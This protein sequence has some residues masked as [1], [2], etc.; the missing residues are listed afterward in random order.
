MTQ[1]QLNNNKASEES[2][3]QK[4]QGSV[5]APSISM[6]KGGGAIRGIGEKFAANP[7]TGTGSMSVPIA[8]SPGRAG[9]G[10]QL[11]LSYDSGAGNGPFG[12][13]W[14]MSLPS[15]TRKT[16][17]GLPRYFNAEDSDEFILSGA[18]DLV[19]VLFQNEVGQ[20]IEDLPTRKINNQRYTIRGYRPRIEGLFARIER[21]TNQTDPTDVFWRSISKDNITTW[22]GK[23]EESRIADPEDPRRIFSWLICESHDD[24]GNV[25][26]YRYKAED[27]VK[28][29]LT[30]AHESNRSDNSRTANRYLKRI[31]YGHFEP[32]YPVLSE[33]DPW[34][35]P[36]GGSPTKIESEDP[37]WHF[38]AVFDYG[39]HSSSDSLTPNEDQN[40]QPRA[41]PFSSFR[42]GFEIR[43]YRLCQR[44]L[45]F[46]HF[47]DEPDVGENCLVRS[48][49]FN[50]AYEEIDAKPNPIHTVLNSVTQSG[51]KKTAGNGYQKKSLPPLEFEYSQPTIS[52]KIIEVDAE[53]LEN[54]PYGLDGSVYQWVDLDGE[55]LSGILTE[56]AT[57]WF[58]KANLSP[59]PQT[60]DNG[61]PQAISAK[62]APVRQVAEKPSLAA[63]NSGRQQFLDLAG[64][65]QLDLVELEGSTPGFY[66]RTHQE[67]WESHRTFESLPNLEWADPNLKFIDLTGDGHADIMITED[68][69]F[70]WFPSLAEAG[71]GPPAYISKAL[72]EDQ[73]PRLVFADSTQSIYLSDMSG[74]GLTDMVRLRNGEVCYWPNLGYG[75]FGA[76]ITMDNAPWYDYPDLFDQKR[77][78]LADIDGSGIADILYLSPEG[79]KIYYNQSGNGWSE[80]NILAGFPPIDN[81]STVQAMDLLGNG[82][83][84][85]VWSSPLSANAAQPMRYIDLMGGQ[86]PHLLIKSTNNLG[87][88]THVYYAPSTKFYLQDRYNSKPWVTKI[89]FPVHVV[90]RVE[91]ID[92]ISKSRFSSHY[93]YHHG[94]FDGVEREFRGFGMVEQWDTEEYTAIEGN[95][96]FLQ[97]TNIDK[98]SHMPPM[99]TKTWFHTGAYLGGAEI[100]LLFAKDYYG[101]PA[102]DD[103]EYDQKFTAFVNEQLLPDTILEPGL[104]VEEARGACRSLKGAMLRQE[105]Y[106]DDGTD[107]AQH[108]YTVT[109]QNFTIRYLQPR[110]DSPHAVFF[111]HAREALS[112]H[113]ERN[114]VDPRIQH[115]L[116]LEVDE[117]GN[118]LKSVAIGYGRQ[119]GNSPIHGVD[120]EKQE[121]LLITYTEND[122]TRNDGNYSLTDP[123]KS[124]DVYRIPLPCETRTYE[125]TGLQPEQNQLRFNIDYFT[126]NNFEN[127]QT[128]VSIEYEK[129]PDTNA[130]Q[131]RLIEHVR[132]LYKANQL[133]GPLALGELQSLALPYE[134]YKLAFTPGFL[135]TVFKRNEQPL[136][137]NIAEVLEKKAGDGGGYV[138]LD[139]DG[140]WWI[141]SGRIFFS[142]NETD[143]PQA[144]LALARRSFFT[145]RRYCDPFGHSATVDFDYCLLIKETRDALGNTA[146]AV[147]DFR[148]LQPRQMTDPNGNRTAADF[149]A[150]GLVVATALMGKENET[151]P[152]NIGDTLADPTTRL[153]YELF[154]WK[155]HGQ[156]NF[157]HTSARERHG[158]ANPRWQESY[159]YSDG[160]GR[161]LQTKIQAE[162]GNAPLREESDNPYK[163][164]ALTK[165]AEGQLIWTHTNPRWVGT[166]RTVYN[167]K[168]KPVKQYEPFFSSTPL[169]EE[170]REVTDTGVSPVLFYDPV[171][172]VI[173]TLHPNHTYDKVMFDPWRQ[174]TYD[175]N[176]T[177]AVSGDETGDPRTDPDIAGYV[178][179]YFEEQ[180]ANWQ[181]WYEQRIDGA[182]GDP[183]RAAAEKAAAYAGTPAMAHFD[184]L[185]RPFLTVAHNKVKCPGHH[186]DGAEERFVTRVELDIEG[187]QRSVIDAKGRVVMRYDY[188]M[189]GTVIHQASMEAGERWLL[190]DITGKPIRTW[191]S[192]GFSHRMTYDALRRPVDHYLSDS[193]QVEQLVE[194]TIYGDTPYDDTPETL[195]HPEQTNHRGRPYKVYDNA[196]VVTSEAY[197][198][199]GNLLRSSRQLRH[200]YKNTADWQQNPELE[201]E[202]FRSR[203]W[204][205]A[206][207]RPI[208]LVAPHS[209]KPGTRFNVLRP[210]YNEANLLERV[211]AWLQQIEEP[212]DLLVQDTATLHAVINIDY[213]AKGQRTLIECG[214]G[215]ATSYEY[216]PLTYRLTQL[217]TT[218]SAGLNG[219]GAQLFKDNGS[220]QD[221][222]YSYDPAGNITRIADLALP[223]MHFAGQQVEPAADYTYDA[224]YRLIEASGR[225]HIGQ[226]A[227]RLDSPNGNC[228]DYPFAGFGPQANDP[229][230]V[231]GYTERYV[232]DAVGNFLNFIHQANGASWQRDYEYE[233]DSLLEPNAGIFSNRL[234]RTV[235]HPNGNNPIVEPYHYDAHGSMIDMPHLPSMQW[236][237]NDQLS[238]S[239]RQVN[240]N[241]SAE[242]T[243]Y[244]YD[245]TGQRV[246]KIT[247]GQNG[248]PSKERIYLGGF[249]IYREYDGNGEDTTLERE[250]LHIMDDKQRI[251]LVE[252]KTVDNDNAGDLY[253]PVIRYQLGNHLGS[254]SLE[255]DHDGSVISYEEYHPYGTTAF[256]AGRSRAEVSLKRYRYTGMERDE[257]TGLNYHGARYYA[258]W[259]G[260]W[261]SCDPIGI[262]G[263]ID[264]YVFV[265]GNPISKNDPSGMQEYSPCDDELDAGV[266]SCPSVPEARL[267]DTT[268]AVGDPA[269]LMTDEDRLDEGRP[270]ATAGAAPPELAE[271][272]YVLAGAGPNEMRWARKEYEQG[273]KAGVF[274]FVV[275]PLPLILPSISSYRPKYQ[276]EIGDEAAS[277]TVLTLMVATPL[278]G[279]A[280][281]RAIGRLR[282]QWEGFKV[283]RGYYSSERYSL[284]GAA[285]TQWGARVSGGISRHELAFFDPRSTTSEAGLLA[286][287]LK[288]RL[289]SFGNRVADRTVI[290][291]SSTYQEGRFDTVVTTSNRES[292]ELLARGEVPL[293]PRFRLGPPPLLEHGTYGKLLPESHVEISG[294][295]SLRLRWG[296]NIGVVTGTSLPACMGNCTPRWYLGEFPTTLHTNLPYIEPSMRNPQFFGWN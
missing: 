231:R 171:G 283:S 197:D 195:A 137:T 21:W 177:V 59:L 240:N 284:G 205:D 14:N 150:L 24:K 182:P 229:K 212:E 46:H 92:W 145:P 179:V 222:R 267:P 116:T 65:G 75:R 131:K 138:Q 35:I 105:V 241:G 61:K 135:E 271:Q 113:Y 174:T 42:A 199:K 232:Y 183:E 275:G 110:A 148:V 31:L 20:W 86:K 84:C 58:Y 71:F 230:A 276:T 79:V 277:D 151:D 287:R 233:E 209:D 104:P 269:Y 189:L 170:E 82:T 155:N 87:A 216:D 250:T 221:L 165:D 154:A 70:C 292:W 192:R 147:N 109:E 119:P 226:S 144:E 225:E 17:K 235:L 172:R 134:S 33:N 69:V 142:P 146:R 36:P 201:P 268:D 67:G 202:I 29:P 53:S 259:L 97:Y 88:E 262:N 19:P 234:S 159:L 206:L 254:A 168:G 63:L 180:P 243:Y 264:L 11:S 198:F 118:V 73:G 252:T 83:A 213:N 16:D 249:E 23:T 244:V 260:R 54:L 247:E 107:K 45:M 166:G 293:P 266:G 295:A 12:L 60:D 93:A 103:P 68:D 128:L 290:G 257:E 27:S 282:L 32:Y 49:D 76:K 106:A 50:Y 126:A 242:T 51:Y 196:G 279:Y 7:V 2:S 140:Y 101:A 96:E 152:Q 288:L 52:E 143:T 120:K 227:F 181:T 203:T 245:A 132:T 162:P 161:E 129:T 111:T 158:E 263:N 22:Y 4:N 77:I 280:S 190:N 163:P 294:P 30:Q 127:L 5:S 43:T 160:F 114:P 255:L 85:L 74:D 130:K 261:C 28:L 191:D 185:G 136:L 272:G 37:K 95:D 72:E 39:D 102:P 200:G 64:D 237:F 204:Y 90:E 15:I 80:V 81:L 184:A 123:V 13:G 66:E 167:N 133:T 153:E 286:G 99:H 91:T 214:N 208:Q 48:T 281:T 40:W 223:V 108:P 141:P 194:K 258:L 3:E 215:S 25:I 253:E 34:P 251:A 193:G 278:A 56:Q 219:L 248:K 44:M 164:G 296:S 285:D 175:V 26:V 246:R 224:L 125:V 274:D 207:N 187:N 217:R 10:P 169:Y 238:A 89:P 211:D 265:S 41:D 1:K 98:A 218:R 62:F 38:E 78:R 149:D 273:V 9:F 139:D 178:R 47:P 228:R 55:G 115:A 100:S 8:V 188:D 256:Q 94:Y 291:V 18:E 210:A 57:G 186:L 124:R 236:D 220:I 157:V 117:F 270:L 112:Y 176:D 6:P 289:K 121:Q 239:S 173:A 156:P 122:L